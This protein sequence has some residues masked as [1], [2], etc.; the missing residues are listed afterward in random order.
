M[1]VVNRGVGLWFIFSV[2]LN[3][4]SAADAQRSRARQRF[5]FRACRTPR[6]LQRWL[7]EVFILKALFSFSRFFLR[8]WLRPQ[9]AACLWVPSVSVLVTS[10]YSS[11]ASMASP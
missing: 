11:I 3:P 9:G 2:M 4:R 8:S 10:S 1:R 7:Q 5:D 6:L